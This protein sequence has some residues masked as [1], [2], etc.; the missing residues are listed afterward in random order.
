MSLLGYP[1]EITYTKFE[2]FGIFRFSVM[3]QTDR[4]TDKQTDTKILPTPSDMVSIFLKW[5]KVV[6]S[7]TLVV[8]EFV[9]KDQVKHKF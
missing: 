6:T 1:K 2:H 5:H 7:M 3:P 4:Q 9:G 8:V